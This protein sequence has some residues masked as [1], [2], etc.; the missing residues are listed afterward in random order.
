MQ[1]KIDEACEAVQAAA[2]G[3]SKATIRRLLTAQFQARGASLPAPLF[4]QAVRQIAAGTYVRG[5]PLISVRRGG[6]LR[7]PFIGK[8]MGRP[9]QSAL[10]VLSHEGMQPGVFR[11]SDHVA[12]AWQLVSGALPHPPGRALFAPT[13]D[14]VPPPARL[15]PDP[16]LR[17]RIPGLFEDPPPPPKW[18]G[19]PPPAQGTLF[20]VWL[21]EGEGEDVMV[22]CPP[23]RIGLLAA[24]SADAYLPL[25]RWAHVQDKVVAA[26]ADIRLTDKGVAPVT[27]RVIPDRSDSGSQSRVTPPAG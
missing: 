4:E 14:G 8:A 5:A 16:D 18:V 25:V 26:T 10:D 27:V 15:I 11:V 3:K 19:V 20:F 13:P 7:L 22:C 1:D 2:G 24:E 9:L 23:G 21:E 17:E 12:Y 6:L